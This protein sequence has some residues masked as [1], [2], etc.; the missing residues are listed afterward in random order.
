MSRSG[1]SNDL[2]VFLHLHMC[3]GGGGGRIRVRRGAYIEGNDLVG[4]VGNLVQ[5]KACRRSRWLSNPSLPQ[6]SLSVRWLLL[7]FSSSPSSS[8]YSLLVLLLS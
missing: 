3:G 2:E 1:D 7:P 8:F 4:I 5:G 6:L